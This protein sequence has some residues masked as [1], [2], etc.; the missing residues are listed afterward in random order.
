MSDPQLTRS[1]SLPAVVLFGITYMTPIIV[2]GTFGV[3]ATLTQGH[4]P[5]AYLL[6]SIAMLFTAFSYSR[7]AAEFLFPALP[8]LMFDMG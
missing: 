7:M 4:V 1:L 3:L 2:L 6:A 8:T 5:T